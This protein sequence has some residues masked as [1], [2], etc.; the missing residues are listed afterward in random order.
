MER[1]E[2]KITVTKK[3]I[4][5]K[6]ECHCSADI[7][8]PS[9][10]TV[11][12]T[13][14]Y[15]L[16]S[17][18]SLDLETRPELSVS[19]QNL[20]AQ[21]EYCKQLTP[22]GEHVDL[23]SPVIFYDSARTMAVISLLSEAIHDKSF[24]PQEEFSSNDLVIIPT[25]VKVNIT[26]V[27]CFKLLRTDQIAGNDYVD[28]EA[29]EVYGEVIER[30]LSLS[31]YLTGKC[32]KKSL[33]DEL[34]EIDFPYEVCNLVRLTENEDPGI[35]YGIQERLKEHKEYTDTECMESLVAKLNAAKT[36]ITFIVS[37]T[38]QQYSV[39]IIEPKKPGFFARLTGKKKAESEL[40]FSLKP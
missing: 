2:I 12:F 7:D 17:S 38:P 20:L 14:S 28:P 26:A 25:F 36:G 30:R 11:T 27:K 3:R 39:S 1:E 15:D 9:I 18:G 31:N 19:L 37:D 5:S 34:L 10:A 4:W 33:R 6:Y 24:V 13:V 8:I 32:E 35:K 40:H 21:S 22:E 16:Y 23:T 29:I